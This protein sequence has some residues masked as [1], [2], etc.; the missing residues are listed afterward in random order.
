MQRPAPR[1]RIQDMHPASSVLRTALREEL[2]AGLSVRIQAALSEARIRQTRMR[3][4]LSLLSSGVSAV[5]FAEAVTPS[6]TSSVTTAT[7]SL[8]ET[9]LSLFTGIIFMASSISLL[10]RAEIAKSIT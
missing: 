7:P 5:S 2:P 4:T 1:L 10:S 6:A 8:V 9:T 3:H